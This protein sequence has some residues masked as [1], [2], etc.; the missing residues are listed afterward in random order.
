MSKKSV[1]RRA[2]LG[3]AAAA[4]ALPLPALAQAY[5]NRPV[6]IVVGFPPGGSN[7]AVARMIQPAVAEALGQPVVVENRPGANA[8]LG[9]E[10]VAR[11]A[12]DGYTLFVGSSSP[13]VIVPHMSSHVS[14]VTPRDFVT[15]ATVAMTPSV[16]AIGPTMRA[17][18]LPEFIEQA[19]RERLNI[20]SAGAGGLGH[21]A[22]EIMRRQVGPEITHV[23]YRGASPAVVDVIGGNVDG[24]ILDLAGLYGTLQEGKLRALGVMSKTRSALQPQVPTFSEIGVPGVVAV[25]WAAVLAPAATPRAI[26]DRLHT[27]LRHI[28]TSGDMKGRFATLGLEPLSHPS[29]AAAH[30]FISAEYAHWGEVVRTTGVKSDN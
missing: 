24:L 14:Y 27:V 15:L 10:H 7:D 3:A 8:T 20:A 28:A 12:P 30:E 17:R 5:P 16:L 21:L 2:L 9:A 29:Q 11:S 13:L 19:K 26:V 18:T 6:R 23:P 22:I 4:A 1:P 25:N